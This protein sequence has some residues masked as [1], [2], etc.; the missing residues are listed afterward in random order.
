M[1]TGETIEITRLLADQA[2]PSGSKYNGGGWGSGWTPSC[3]GGNPGSRTIQ[4]N[5]W[6][7]GRTII[8]VHASNAAGKS[9]SGSQWIHTL[10]IP[11]FEGNCTAN[12]QTWI[13]A[14]FRKIATKLQEG[15]VLYDSYLDNTVKAFKKGCLTREGIWWRLLAE[16]QNLN[17]AP[18]KC[19]DTTD[20]KAAFASFEAY[21]G[22]IYLRWK[23]TESPSEYA[24]CHEL[25]H[26]AGFHN[27]LYAC[28]LSPNDI[29]CDADHVASAILGL[30]PDPC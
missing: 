24:L 26:K 4:G 7:S 13:R 11:K 2:N 14:S 12:R 1:T 9:A 15:R 5:Q 23:G 17:I 18:I 20:P 29:E 10:G 16:L 3:F 21:T 6:G 19:E 22:R 27:S 28:G 25:V 8:H 30:Q